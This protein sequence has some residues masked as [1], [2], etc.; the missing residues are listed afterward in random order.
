[1]TRY[2]ASYDTENPKCLAGVRKIVAVHKRYSMPA[3]FYI[4]GKTL[5][6]DAA[7]YRELLD[8][9]LFEVATHTYSHKV[10]IDHP[11]CGKSE[12]PD[13]VR[14][15]VLRGTDCV[16]S[17]FKRKCVGIRPGCSFEF[18]LRKAPGVLALVKEAGLKYVSSMA[19][20]RDYSLPAPLNQSFRY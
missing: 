6:G 20:G 13:G 8:D 17:V 10:L 1:M 14:E 4:T 16:E 9:P 2:I 11:F 15:Q 18:G 12:N 7:E 5:E 3:T 19:W